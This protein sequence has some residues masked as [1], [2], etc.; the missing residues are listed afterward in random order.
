MN[1]VPPEKQRE[2][3]ELE[4]LIQEF[5]ERGGRIR[6]IPGGVSGKPRKGSK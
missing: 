2:H 1:N 6:V 5:L 3:E 4:R